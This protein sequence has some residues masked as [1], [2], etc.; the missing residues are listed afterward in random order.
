MQ[1]FEY[2]KV[3]K[4]LLGFTIIG[5]EQGNGGMRMK[6]VELFIQGKSDTK[7]CE[8]GYFISDNFVAVIDGVTSKSDFR[9]EGKTTGKLAEDAVRKAVSALPRNA[10]M[11]Q[12]VKAVND[13]IAAFYSQIDFPYDRREKG[14]QAVCAA[15]SDHLRQV[16]LIG[17]CQAMIDGRLYTNPKKSDEVLSEMRSLILNVLLCGGESKLPSQSQQKMARE[18]IEPWILRSNCFANGMGSEYNYAVFNGCDIP[19][20]LIQVIQLDEGQHEIVLA[21]DGYPELRQNLQASETCLKKIL[22]DDPACYRQYHS[23][24]GVSSEQTSFDDRTYIRFLI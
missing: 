23:T 12:F 22:S 8:D 6:L 5:V 18:V 14:L 13:E 15:Y 19:A 16:W 10:S 20:E 1:C 7:N 4:Q 9:Y 17:D 21:S 2:E 24:K 11:Q 3:W